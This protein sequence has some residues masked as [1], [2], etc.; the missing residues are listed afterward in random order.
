MSAA[1]ELGMITVMLTGRDGGYM[2]H[3]LGENALEIR[4]SATATARIQEVNILVIHCLCDLVDQILFG[5]K[6]EVC[7]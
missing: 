3:Q 5:G 2:A 4:I 6:R 7:A 1:R